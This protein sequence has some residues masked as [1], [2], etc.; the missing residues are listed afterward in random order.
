MAEHDNAGFPLTYCLLTTA[1]AIDQG[2]RTKALMAWARCLR[3]QYKIAPVFAH[4]DKD[5]AEI[6]C[7]REVWDAK[8]SLCW[9]HLRRAIRTRLNMGKLATTPYN[10]KRA[11]TEFSFIDELFAPRGKKT[12]SEDYEG[13]LPEASTS[14]PNPLGNISNKLRIKIPLHLSN[15]TSTPPAKLAK[16]ASADKENI[17]TYTETHA[18]TG[19]GMT[20]RIP[21]TRGLPATQTVSCHDSDKDISDDEEDGTGPSQHTFCPAVYRDS[22]IEKIERHYCAHVLIPGYA[23]PTA[24]GIK[25]WAV[26]Q[27]YNFCVKHEL[28]EVWAYLWENWYR[29]GRWELWARSA[30]QEIPVLKT[31]MILESQ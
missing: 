8:I 16:S 14:A 22:I 17:P 7:L 20:I 18:R 5:M 26:Q 2:K 15:P 9:W 19:N 6:G 1:T 11:H 30:H 29:K 27:M 31:T 21:A 24:A 23:Q 12:D 3:D 10:A 25:R 4:V 13:G 28:R